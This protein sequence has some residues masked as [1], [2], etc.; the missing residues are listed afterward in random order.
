V[1][2]GEL[3]STLILEDGVDF[4]QTELTSGAL[5]YANKYL[6][7]KE[8]GR[9][10]KLQM[11]SCAYAFLYLKAA[12]NAALSELGEAH[13]LIAKCFDRIG[14]SMWASKHRDT[15]KGYLQAKN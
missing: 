3:C 14:D 9:D 13:E 10:E 5:N 2:S 1:T 11:L 7:Q 12:A 15:A 6:A 4:S 8:L